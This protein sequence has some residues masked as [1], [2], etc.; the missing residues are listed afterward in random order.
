MGGFDDAANRISVE[1]L[2]GAMNNG[3]M[4]PYVCMYEQCSS[5]Y[6]CMYGRRAHL[7]E[8]LRAAGR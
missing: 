5:M 3:G 1:I 4:Q 6:D 2:G 8:I 7:D